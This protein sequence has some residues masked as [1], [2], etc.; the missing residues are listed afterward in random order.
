[1]DRDSDMQKR[2]DG[3]CLITLNISITLKFTIKLNCGYAKQLL[4]LFAPCGRISGDV[5][6]KW[7]AAGDYLLYKVRQ[8]NSEK[9]VAIRTD[10]VF[11]RSF[12]GL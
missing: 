9:S 10:N 4:L 7:M 8:L 12:W 1:M 2:R 6:V 5:F 11:R 3:T